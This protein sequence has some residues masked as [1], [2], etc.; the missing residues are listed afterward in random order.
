[1]WP[2]TPSWYFEDDVYLN[3]HHLAMH[4][5]GSNS[6]RTEATNVA[7]DMATDVSIA[8]EKP[9]PPWWRY[10]NQLRNQINTSVLVA[11]IRKA[12]DRVFEEL[13]HGDNYALRRLYVPC[14][15]CL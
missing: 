1:M 8:K 14:K 10:I 15:I 12:P 6:C 5:H 3:L 4:K 11:K 7:T 13:S 9:R 2:D